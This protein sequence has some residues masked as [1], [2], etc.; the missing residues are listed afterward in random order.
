MDTVPGPH[1]DTHLALVKIPSLTL[2][3]EFIILFC[4]MPTDRTVIVEKPVDQTWSE[5][6]ANFTFRCLADSDSTTATRYTWLYN[7][8]I[9]ITGDEDDLYI[10]DA[11]TLLVI[12]N[13]GLDRARRRHGRY[14]CNA[15]NGYSYDL[16]A[17]QFIVPLL[18]GLDMSF[19]YHHI[20][21]KLG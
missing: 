7:D 8:Q 2:N 15:T 21:H 18:P 11:G 1:Q 20:C 10:D 19:T 3:H 12:Y 13:T 4:S 17:A 16:S 6:E 14:Q 9:R 5:N